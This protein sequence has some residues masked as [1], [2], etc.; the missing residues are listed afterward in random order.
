VVAAAATS[1]LPSLFVSA[2]WSGGGLA[3]MMGASV[4]VVDFGFVLLFC[5]MIFMHWNTWQR[6]FFN[7]AKNVCRV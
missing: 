4:D 1:S 6:G 2:P 3:A 5:E 7:V